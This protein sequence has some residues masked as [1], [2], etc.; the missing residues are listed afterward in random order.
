MKLCLQ[1]GGRV[2]S[3]AWEFCGKLSRRAGGHSVS[4]EDMDKARKPSPE[5]K[6][7][8]RTGGGRL[9]TGGVRED[10]GE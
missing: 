3:L 5:E 2:M 7:S 4:L 6:G 10:V 1:S 8:Q 9:A